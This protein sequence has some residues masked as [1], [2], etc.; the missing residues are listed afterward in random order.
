[1]D[2]QRTHAHGARCRDCNPGDRSDKREG[3]ACRMDRRST[4]QRGVPAADRGHGIRPGAGRRRER[5][6]SR[7]DRRHGR[8]AGAA[9]RAEGPAARDRPMIGPN[10]SEWSIR[11]P[12]LVIYLMIAAVIAGAIAFTQ[13]GRA[14]DPVFTFRT[15]VVQA[16]W[17]GATLE[18]TVQQV[19][20]R[21]ER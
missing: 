1:R 20:D 6:R 17:P 21:I 15:M 10:L 4:D 12:S 18:D 9:A 13:L 11:R 19:T 5:P 2:G 8:R 14:E 3:P 16:A 7:R